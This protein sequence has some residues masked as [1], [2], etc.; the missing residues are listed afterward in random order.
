MAKFS[1]LDTQNRAPLYTYCKLKPLILLFAAPAAPP[2]PP[3]PPPGQVKL[4]EGA[5]APQDGR[6]DL[7]ASIRNASKNK[8]KSVE[9]RKRDKKEEIKK[10]KE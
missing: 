9:E 7:L 8:L 4:P 6:G 1:K 5:P 3:P 10:T 2:P